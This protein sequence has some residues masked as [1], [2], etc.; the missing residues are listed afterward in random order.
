MIYLL[1][2]F[3]VITISAI[4]FV[5]ATGFAQPRAE[6]DGAARPRGGH[7]DADELAARAERLLSRYGI[8]IESRGPSGAGELTLV[9][10]SADALIG[11]RYIVVCLA[12]PDG[13]AV[14]TT[15]LLGFRDEVKA[16]GATKGL[17]IT[18]GRFPA[19][20]PLLL[21]DAPISL[22]TLGH[23]GLVPA[24]IAPPLGPPPG[25]PDGGPDG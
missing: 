3:F 14:P 2:L 20:A 24:A 13:E 5:L 23:G 6:A 9:G 21:E 10:T 19:D 25:G 16:S 15:R 12:S 4:V 7:V 11:G 18:D 22:M 1:V 17:F 8:E